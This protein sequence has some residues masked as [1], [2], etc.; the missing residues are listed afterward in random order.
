[1]S[2]GVAGAAVRGA[3]VFYSSAKQDFTEDY[4]NARGRVVLSVATHDVLDFRP[5]L[6]CR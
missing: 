1:M 2:C 6:T 5:C 3:S 4:R